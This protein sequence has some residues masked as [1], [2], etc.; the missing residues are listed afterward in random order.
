MSEDQGSRSFLIMHAWHQWVSFLEQVRFFFSFSKACSWLWEL[1]I[2]T[3]KIAAMNREQPTLALRGEV[4]CAF[5][6]AK[7]QHG[8]GV[9]LLYGERIDIDDLE[10]ILEGLFSFS[11]FSSPQR[12]M[13]FD[14]QAL[15][16]GGWVKREGRREKEREIERKR[17]IE[18]SQ[19]DPWMRNEMK[20][21]CWLLN[22]TLASGTENRSCRGISDTPWLPV[23][24]RT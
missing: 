14:R 16:R 15:R 3:G 8:A 12:K 9:V 17:W 4:W 24:M 23:F 18:K 22:S 5:P 6:S 1:R 21:R 11:C 10:F 13:A 19:W 20:T 7:V 2:I